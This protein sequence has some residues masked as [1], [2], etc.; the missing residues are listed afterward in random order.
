MP[1]ATAKAA[2]RI[3]GHS[4]DNSGSA[5]KE[6]CQ[7]A[8]EQHI[9]IIIA[10]ND[11]RRPL[12]TIEERM[13]MHGTERECVANLTATCGPSKV[14]EPR[15]RRAR[16]E[17]EGV[18]SLAPTCRIRIGCTLAYER[19]EGSLF[20]CCLQVG[21]R[22]PESLRCCCIMYVCMHGAASFHSLGRRGGIKRKEGKAK[23]R[24]EKKS[25]RKAPCRHPHVREAVSS[26]ARSDNKHKRTADSRNSDL[27]EAP[28]AQ[29]GSNLPSEQ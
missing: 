25:K 8:M 5:L 17:G 10:R 20:S 19:G 12:G 23:K 4:K 11:H 21:A 6:R 2:F 3:H 15:I 22:S 26:R 29:A 28:A 27:P 13:M 1:R 24:K 14:S 18:G 7:A 16:G 9:V